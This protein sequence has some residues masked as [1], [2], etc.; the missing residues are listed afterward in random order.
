MPR[1]DRQIGTALKL[2]KKN[3]QSVQW[4]KQV[5]T[6]NPAEPWNET[7]VP[8]VVGNPFICFLPL[9]LQGKQF[10][11]SLG[12]SPEIAQGSYYGL[13]GNVNFE[14]STTDIVIRDG[15]NLEI[16]TIDLLSPNGQ[17]IL[18]TVIFNK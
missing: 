2:I 8:T 18:W 9:D 4:V 15:K 6:S 12:S 17:L 13:M 10:L 7:S 5:I 14:P 3:G 1:F 11:V 16:S